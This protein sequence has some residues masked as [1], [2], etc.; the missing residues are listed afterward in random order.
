MMKIALTKSADRQRMSIWR[1]IVKPYKDEQYKEEKSKEEKSDNKQLSFPSGDKIEYLSRVLCQQIEKE[2]FERKYARAGDILKLVGAGVF[3]AA[4]VAVP[5]LPLVLK[6]FLKNDQEPQ[7][8]KRFNI[9]LLKRTLTRLEE[10]KYVEIGVENGI[11]IV[12]I[13]NSGRQKILKYALDEWII[14]KPK[15]WDRKWRLVSFDLPEK[16]S[17]ERKVLVEYMKAWKFYPLHKSVYLHAYPCVK[18]VSFLREFL[19][20][21]EYIRIFIVSD[22]ENPEPFREFF[23]V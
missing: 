10:E 7:A 13:T 8:W 14:K 2:A 6:P 21:G 22:I 9:P 15:L 11:Q 23:G 4:S 12:K 16:F 3:L 1:N 18:A 5:N 20:V 19:G 17:K